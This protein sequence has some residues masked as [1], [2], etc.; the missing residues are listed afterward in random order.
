MRLFIRYTAVLAL[1]FTEPVFAEDAVSI[2]SE[3]LEDDLGYICYEGGT[4]KRIT[5]AQAI[6]MAKMIDGETWGKPTTEDASAML[7]T[8][9]QRSAIWN[10]KS[11]DLKRLIQGYSQPI[12][13][14]WTRTG[15]RC[16][17]FYTDDFTGEIPEQCSEKR[18]SRREANIAKDW[19]DTAEIARYG[20]LEFAAG[21][22]Q[23]PIVG[24]V[25]WYAPG[26]WRS[27][28][29]KGANAT[30]DRVFHTEVDGNIYFAMSKNPDTTSWDGFEV[31]VVPFDSFCPMIIDATPEN[32][33]GTIDAA[34]DDR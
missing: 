14:I 24:G 10:F 32:E 16:R 2:D 18:V 25:G 28:E 15:N 19:A 20:V 22:T 5:V 17:E 1:I 7:W 3:P 26:L 31:T 34:P 12:N 9:I 23:N 11:W 30:H 13:P 8:L 21:R 33:V 4:E 27:M 29:E 6:W